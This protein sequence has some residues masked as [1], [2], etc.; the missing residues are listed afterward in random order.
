M[1]VKEESS[2]IVKPFYDGNEDPPST[3]QYIPLSVFDK[4][5]FNTHIVDIYAYRPPPPQNAI[6][7]LGLRKAL[8]PYRECAGRLGLNDKDASDEE[9][10]VHKIHFA[11]Q[12]LAKL[13]ARSS[14]S[15]VKN[16]P[17]STFKSLVAH[18]WRAITKARGLNGSETTTVRIYM[19]GRVRLNLKVPREYFRSLVLWAFPCA[20]VKDQAHP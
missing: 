14:S 18:L 13:K 2:K 11:V 5:T 20:K 15:N 16:E 6:L 19:N 10:V 7:E 17:Y 9:I 1:K 8:S 12:F 4:V 3:K